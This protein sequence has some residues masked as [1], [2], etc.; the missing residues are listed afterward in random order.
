MAHI[1]AAGTLLHTN[2][3]WTARFHETGSDAGTGLVA[4]VDPTDHASLEAFLRDPSAAEED[5]FRL[6]ED[7]TTHIEALCLTPHP[8]GGYCVTARVQTPPEAPLLQ[9]QA[10]VAQHMEHGVIVADADERIQWVN[11]GFTRQ[12]GYPLDEVIGQR[13]GDLLCG[14]ET[15]AE[16]RAQLRQ[17]IATGTPFRGEITNHTRSGR[18]YRAH[19]DLVP[20]RGKDGRVQHLLG[21]RQ[22]I[23]ARHLGEQELRAANQALEEH[24]REQTNSLQTTNLDLEAFIYSASHDLRAPLRQITTYIELIEQRYL[25]MGSP[26]D[27]QGYLH[28]IADAG[29]GM[30]EL[31]DA[32]LRLSRASTAPFTPQPVDVNT[33]VDELIARAHTLGPGQRVTWTRRP[34]PAVY[35]DPDLLRLALW[36][37]VE[38]ALKYSRTRA[39]P[40][41]RLA[42]RR[43]ADGQ[44]DIQVEDNGVGFAAAQAEELFDPFVRGHHAVP[45]EGTGIG[46][47][48]VRRIAL[49]HGGTVR[50]HSLGEQGAVFT[51]SLPFA[52]VSTREALPG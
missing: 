33:L 37:L 48:V 38:N 43:G 1:D 32:L 46:L 49:R 25:A 9:L 40:H 31:L 50:A 12:T 10:M 29:M 15:E 18:A 30:H 4:L 22:D 51:L 24:I 11:P 5:S 28:A 35:G 6:H 34:I 17:A 19:L 44:I 27:I 20:I 39:L 36:N 2:P 7:T 8:D 3:A 13:P 41:I 47:A 14:P 16:V 26:A 21:V 45:F 23:T 42:G 52:G